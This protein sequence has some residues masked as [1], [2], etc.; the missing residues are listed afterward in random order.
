MEKYLITEDLHYFLK[1]KEFVYLATCA[2]NHQPYVAPKFLIRIDGDSVYLA[3]YV[4]GRAFENLKSNPKVS[5]SILNLDNLMGYQMTGLAQSL[6]KGDEFDEILKDLEK[7]KMHFTV[8]RIVE[9]ARQSKKHEN[10]EVAFP[11]HLA[12][13]KITVEEIV[14]IAPG[15]GVKKS[16]RKK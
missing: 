4:M 13:I 14:H 7:R 8:E 3:D 9:G 10:F 11:D 15:G 1:K 6:E 5:F 12:I 16:S 2:S